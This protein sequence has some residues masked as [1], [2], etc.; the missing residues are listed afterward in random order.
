M[1][2]T[3]N[4]FEVF[5]GLTALG[6][7]RTQPLT[8]E[9]LAVFDA[10]SAWPQ[11][12]KLT[13][14]A[15]L[16]NDGEFDTDFSPYITRTEVGIGRESALDSFRPRAAV[17]SLDNE[18]SRFSPRNT[19]SPYYPNIKRGRKVRHGVQLQMRTVRNLSEN[20]SSEYD[21]VGNAGAGGATLVR[22]PVGFIDDFESDTSAEYTTGG[23]VAAT[24]TWEPESSRL[25]AAGGTQAWCL[26]TGLSLQDAEIEVEVESAHDGG[27]VARYQDNNNYY[28]LGV[29]DDSGTSSTVNLQFYKRVAGGWTSIGA[30]INRAWARGVRHRIR[31][32]VVGTTLTAYWDDELVITVVDADH[33]AAGSIGIRNHVTSEVSYYHR[34]E[35]TDLTAAVA[36]AR[37]GTASLKVTPAAADDSGVVHTKRDG[38]RFAVAPGVSYVAQVSVV[39]SATGLPLSLDLAWYDSASA[40]ISM[41]SV[42]FTPST[43]ADWNEISFVATAPATAAFAQLA[44]LVDDAAYPGGHYFWCDGWAFYDS[45]YVEPYCDGDTAGA[46]WLPVGTGPIAPHAGSES[47]RMTNPT[48]TKFTGSMREFGFLRGLA[49]KEL[50]MTCTGN[51][52]KFVNSPVVA[53][54]YMGTTSIPL[55]P[56]HVLD[57]LMDLLEQG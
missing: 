48:K 56:E 2:W 8:A 31:F 35:V 1:P 13:L 17:F 29:N 40:L 12:P 54:A 36:R 52:E 32:R 25:K 45:P 28:L 33:G 50:L 19:G 41:D 38:T 37:Y 14:L 3:E 6:S 20:P 5:A 51:I 26:R 15:D 18:D 11:A 4:G 9:G 21:I 49:P 23:D 42:S 39:A 57:R 43:G 34:L 53:G 27:L 30:A 55:K 44:V 7:Q 22:D 47:Y 16:N 24:W 10:P 46:S